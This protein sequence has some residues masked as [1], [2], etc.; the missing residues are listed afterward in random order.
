[1]QGNRNGG[2]FEARL[3]AAA[4]TGRPLCGCAGFAR[5]RTARPSG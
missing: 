3:D 1:M 4:W 2:Y 5:I